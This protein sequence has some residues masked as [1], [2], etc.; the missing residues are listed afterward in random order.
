MSEQQ[1]RAITQHCS[2]EDSGPDVGLSINLGGDRELWC[3][4]ISLRAWLDA[5]D[6]AQQLGDDT[7]WW[8][9]LYQPEPLVIAK[10]VSQEAAQALMEAI[11]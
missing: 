4:E 2:E 6:E 8:V 3:G 11:A 5:G 7:G 9:V 1:E 10:C